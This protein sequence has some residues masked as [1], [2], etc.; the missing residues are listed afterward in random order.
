MEILK[1]ICV[2]VV[3]HIQNLYKWYYIWSESYPNF[4]IHGALENRNRKK[5]KIN[6]I[7]NCGPGQYRILIDPFN[8]F[9]RIVLNILRKACLDDAIGCFITSQQY[10]HFCVPLPLANSWGVSADLHLA[11]IWYIRFLLCKYCL[12]P[13]IIYAKAKL[14]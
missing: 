9:W 10:V 12:Y 2:C 13:W 6:N 7:W 11:L 5:R 8:R 14:G 3:Y 1:E 4:I